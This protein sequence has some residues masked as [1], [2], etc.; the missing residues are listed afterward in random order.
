MNRL[1]GILLFIISGFFLNLNGVSYGQEYWS[2]KNCIDYALENN[3][4]LKRRELAA[5]TS[6]QN[7]LQSKLQILPS[8]G[9]FA[10]HNYSSGKTINLDT[11][12]YVQQSFQDGNMGVQATMDL[13]NGLQQT[14]IIKRNKY[15]FM[16]SVANVDKEK[17]DMIINI[18]LYYMKILFNEEL[19]SIAQSQLE[20]INKQV[21][22]IAKFVEVG[23]KPRG[24]LLD[25]QS[26]AA[27]ERLNLTNVKNQLKT[28]YLDLIQ[29]LDLDSL[30]DF[31][32]QK[33]DSTE[34][35]MEHVILPF[36]EVYAAAVS[37]FP[38]IKSAEYSLMEQK[39]SLSVARGQI[40]PR[41]SL[42][43]LIYTRYSQLSTNFLDPNSPYPFINQMDDNQYQQISMNLRIPIF[44]QWIIQNNISNARIS[45]LDAKLNLDVQKQILYKSIQQTHLDAVAALEKYRTSLEVVESRQLAFD[46]S[47]EKLNAG[48]ENTT[49]YNIAKNNFIQAQAE[50]LQAKYEFIFT[51]KILDFYRGISIT[52][53]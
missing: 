32:V 29:L 33:P 13:F 3:L 6:Q 43:G 40:S 47:E 5:R 21:E 34:I 19:Y 41:L 8:V 44:Q 35:D 28:S 1:P 16:A 38:E 46:Y 49:D 22:R 4:Q 15:N 14:N 7:L 25:I 48:L 9:A 30:G 2:L 42:N 27:A 11:Y 53:D 51:T 10:S 39:K 17:N 18:S 26:Q 23:N 31:R 20:A 37:A 52:L 24:D 45:V 50:L 12:E 36:R